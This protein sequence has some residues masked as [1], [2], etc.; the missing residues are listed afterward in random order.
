MDEKDVKPPAKQN[1]NEPESQKSRDKKKTILNQKQQK[2]LGIGA[3][4][5]VA[6]ILAGIWYTQQQAAEH[7][8]TEYTRPADDTLSGDDATT[9]HLTDRADTADNTPNNIPE[10]EITLPSPPKTSNE[11]AE[12]NI[13]EPDEDQA[14][15]HTVNE[16]DENE[17]ES[18]LNA[19]IASTSP[20]TSLSEETVKTALLA[21]EAHIKTLESQLKD[22]Q[23]QQLLLEDS[24]AVQE[25]LLIV[26]DMQR[27]LQ[28]GTAIR[29]SLIRLENAM[30][31]LQTLPGENAR[32]LIEDIKKYSDTQALPTHKALMTRF[33][34]ASRTM[35]QD[36]P[37]IHTDISA[38]QQ[39]EQWFRTQISIKRVAA[40][41][42]T[43][44]ADSLAI[45]AKAE[46]QAK[47]EDMA[48]ALESLKTLT[49]P[50]QT[51]FKAWMQQ[52]ERYCK[53]HTRLDQ[54]KRELITL[55]QIIQ[56][57]RDRSAIT[58]DRK[59]LLNEG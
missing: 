16:A 29:P 36:T 48:S 47:Q 39:V 30:A 32:T 9:E 19:A 10:P 14:H 34:Q 55:R 42:S 28:Q 4:C 33:E 59:A 23:Q 58:L 46:A 40:D 13:S 35:W 51:Y 41:T 44:P 6:A 1:A 50:Q 18:G 57:H 43:V 8:F 22:T 20:P 25:G 26:A 11:K 15:A 3:V 27:F 37:L 2:A 49:I 38:L 5:L 53:T 24:L 56:Q 52:A 54:L 31:G 17:A 45:I 21:Q 7:P 12:H